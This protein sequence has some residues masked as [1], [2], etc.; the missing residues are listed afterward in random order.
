MFEFRIVVKIPPWEISF[1]WVVFLIDKFY[2][3]T[4]NLNFSERGE[5]RY[6]SF[7]IGAFYIKKRAE[8]SFFY[9][10]V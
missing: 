2:V 7:Y 6:P 5:E 10:E 8:G 4:Y 3:K 1:F 9:F